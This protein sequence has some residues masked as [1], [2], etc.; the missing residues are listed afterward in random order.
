MQL[1]TELARSYYISWVYFFF[2]VEQ[3]QMPL[4]QER[5]GYGSTRAHLSVTHKTEK[6]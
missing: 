2:A 4:K 5:A 6:F 1:K 3:S